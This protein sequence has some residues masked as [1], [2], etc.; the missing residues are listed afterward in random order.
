MPLGTRV[1]L[2]MCIMSAALLC[3]ANVEDVSVVWGFLGS[4]CGIM[5]SYVLPAASYL[6]LRR[7]PQSAEK[8]SSDGGDT[9]AKASSVPRRKL[10]AL[11]LVV[12]GLALIPTCLYSTARA[13]WSTQP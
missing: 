9:R 7:T 6:L 10:A 1:V 2:S 4:T 13:V 3:T 12:I 8:R 11:L 5:L